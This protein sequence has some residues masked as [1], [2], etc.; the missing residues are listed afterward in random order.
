[1]RR[2]TSGGLGLGTRPALTLRNCSQ[3]GTSAT[4]RTLRSRAR[5]LAEAR[6]APPDPGAQDRLGREHANVRV[7]RRDRPAT[8]VQ[9]EERARGEPAHDHGPDVDRPAIV[10]EPGGDLRELLAGEVGHR[11]QHVGAGIE[12][13]PAARDRRILA[14]RSIVPVA[15]SCQASASILRIWPRAPGGAAGTPP[16]P[17]VTGS[18]E[19]RRRGAALSGHASRSGG[20]PRRRSSPSAS[21]AA[22]P[23]RP[24]G[25]PSPGRSGG[26]AG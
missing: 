6:A 25:R 15:Q 19:R 13:E 14:P 22:R 23:G 10:L 24:P 7:A 5:R 3:T 26:R 16:G 4:E 8:G 17:A 18:P 9:G 21:R 11:V 1:M 2:P 20:W 12:Q